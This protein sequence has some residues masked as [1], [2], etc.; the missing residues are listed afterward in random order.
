[1]LDL[2]LLETKRKEIQKIV[3][4]QKDSLDKNTRNILGQFSTPFSL[5]DSIIKYVKPLL[6]RKKINF[7]DPAFGTG[8]FFS[9]LLKNISEN[10]FNK[11]FACEIDPDYAKAALELWSNFN[12]SLSISD[13]TKLTP[14]LKEKDKYDFLLCN[15]PYVRHHHIDS[16]EKIRLQNFSQEITGI[17]MNGLTGL[18][19]YFM[20][21]S[22]AWLKKKA[23]SVWL[24][25]REFL[26]VNYGIPIKEYLLK[27]VTLLRIH[28]FDAE[29]LKFHDALVTSAVVIFQNS[30]PDRD[31]CFEFSV[32]KEILSPR[33][34]YIYKLKDL[35]PVTKWSLLANQ[36]KLR[37]HNNNS[38]KLS[39]FFNIQR[40]IA[41]GDNNFF[42]LNE[43]E[44]K[45]KKIPKQILTPILPSP[46]YLKENI[47]ESDRMGN[48]L[49]TQKLFLLN[50]HLQENEIKTIYPH[51]WSYLQSGKDVVSKKYLCRKRKLWYLQEKRSPSFFICTYMGRKISG[52]PFR[53]IFNKSKAIVTNSYLILYPKEILNNWLGNNYKL[54]YTVWEKLNEIELSDFVDCARVYGG[55]LYKIE[56]KELGNVPISSLIDLDK[57][58]L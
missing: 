6:G 23:I 39:H 16:L 8:V 51:L 34:Q 47:I 46:R 2:N 19:C 26:D 43:Q 40:G 14:P 42:I 1:M 25:P 44:I 31:N 35:S 10:R 38:F 7:I 11:L 17:K 24:I 45:E 12:I 20:L 3:D 36:K 4:R 28:L 13:F 37:R 50:C 5:A 49:L 9:A 22:Q 57:E 41:T 55:G 21:I 52:K 32:G 48:P 15:P 58:S 18:Y 30:Q 56:P 53:F 29:D 27:D 33:S 54:A